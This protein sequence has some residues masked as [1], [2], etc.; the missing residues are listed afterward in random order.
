MSGRDNL[1]AARCFSM[2]RVLPP[3]SLIGG[4]SKGV[5]GGNTR[6]DRGLSWAMTKAHTVYHGASVSSGNAGLAGAPPPFPNIFSSL[7]S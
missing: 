7:L 5:T 3:V 1:S 4:G 2:N 6:I